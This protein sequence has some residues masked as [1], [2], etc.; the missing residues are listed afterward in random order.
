[1]SGTRNPGGVS[2]APGMAHELGGS[3]QTYPSTVQDLIREIRSLDLIWRIAS[4][5]ASGA[6]TRAEA[7]L[8]TAGRPWL[9]GYGTTE[10][11]ALAD[12]LAKWKAQS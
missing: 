12:A 3:M 1:M 4:P 2:S 11:A 6:G 10:E 5:G 7:M 9:F 8:R